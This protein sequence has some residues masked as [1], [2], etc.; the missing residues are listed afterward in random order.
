[1]EKFL[2]SNEWQWRLAR[3]IV[4]GVLGVF[5]ANIDLIIGFAVLDPTMR[6]LVVAF[7]MA[8]L[9]PIMAAMGGDDDTPQIPRGEARGA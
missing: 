9:S 1:M 5:I 3:T 8:I 4:Q 6:A 7:V 2:S